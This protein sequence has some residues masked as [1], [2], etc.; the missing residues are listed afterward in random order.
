MLNLLI[1]LAATT[2]QAGYG[3]PA[4]AA[5]STPPAA[6][7]AMAAPST[8][9][10]GRGL[11]E[12]KGVTI[13]YYD[14]AGKDGKAIDKSLK[15]ILAAADPAT[16]GGRVFDWNVDASVTRRTVGTECTIKAVAATLT[17]NVYL[18]RLKEE[19]RVPAE[20]LDSWR[21]YVAGLEKEAAS[22]LWFVNDR[23]PAIQQSMV[24]L[25]C[26]SA[27]SAWET[28]MTKLKQE[29]TAY[30]RQAAATK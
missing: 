9:A 16:G 20:V 21:P 13:K 11:K 15:K 8:P 25:P 10:A 29:S 19:A 5:Q 30:S 17:G 12:L 7:P 18:P 22:N 27:A 24:G 6:P 23:L 26:D 3:A 28:A 1:A 2:A 14:V 4:P